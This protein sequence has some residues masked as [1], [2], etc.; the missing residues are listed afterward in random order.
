[1]KRIYKKK[2]AFFYAKKGAKIHRKKN[3]L[4]HSGA[5][6]QGFWKNEKKITKITA[7]LKVLF[8]P[9]LAFYPS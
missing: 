2:Y 6:K 5:A 1:M 4:F 7:S 8:S 9:L 3:T